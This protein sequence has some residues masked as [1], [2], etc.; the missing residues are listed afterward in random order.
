MVARL[1]FSVVSIVLIAAGVEYEVELGNP[2]LSTY[3]DAVYFSVTTLTTVG[4]GDV[5]PI[6][7]TGRAF[8][9][10]EMLAA[11]TVIPSGLAS[12]AD[13]VRRKEASSANSAEDDVVLASLVRREKERLLQRDAVASSLVNTVCGVCGFDRH[14]WDARYCKRCGKRLP[15]PLAELEE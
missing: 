15:V 9:A 5:V 4:F 3:A 7:P 11:V 1:A 10:L 12:V 2:A 14:D 13:A 6:T 8:V